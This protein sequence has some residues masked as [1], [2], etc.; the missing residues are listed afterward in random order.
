MASNTCR[1]RLF[2]PTANAPAGRAAQPLPAKLTGSKENRGRV[3]TN[4]APIFDFMRSKAH[5]LLDLCEAADG[6][7]QILL[8]MTGG[9]L[10][11]DAVAALRDD[12]IAEAD[13]IDALLEHPAREFLRRARIVE[14]DRNDRMLTGKQVEAMLFH[15]R[16]EIARVGMDAVAQLGGLLKQIDGAQRCCAD[17]GRQRI[18][19]EIGAGTLPQQIDDGL[20]SRSV[21]AGGAAHG[22]TEGAGDDVHPAHDA[23]VFRR[24]AAM[25]THE[26]DGVAVVHHRQRVEFIRKVAD[27]LQVGDIAVHGE[28][29]VGGDENFLAAGCAGRLELG[30]QIVHIVVLIAE[31]LRL[32][33]T[34]AVDDGGVVQLVGNDGV[35][36]AEQRLEQAAV[37][38]EAGGIEDGVVRTDEIGDPALQL[39]MNFLRAADE[40]DRRKAEAPAVI[41]FLRSFDQRG[42]GRKTEIIV[43]AEVY[44]ALFVTTGTARVWVTGVLNGLS[45]LIVLYLVRK[46]ENSAYKV[47]WIALIGLLPLL[48]GALYLAFG[49]KR[50][51]RRL[52]SKMQAVEQ[53]HRAD[54]AQQPGQTAG[55]YDENRGVSRYLTQYGCY[56]AWQ[57]TTARYFSC[58]EAMYPTLLADLEKAE[59]SIFLEFFIVSQGKMWQGV[60]DI[61]RRKAA[62]GVDV[63]LIYD[64]FGS[65]LGLPKD[66][67]V[68]MERA[69]IRCIPFNPV[70]PLLSLVMNH[71]DHRKIVV[72][73]GKVAYTGGINLADE[74]INAITRFGYWKDAG[75]RIEGAAVWNFTVM[76]LDFW[77]AFRPFEQDY[78]AFRPQLAV[79]PASDGVVQPYA[80]SPLDEE[81]VAETV[82]L[83]ILAQSQQYVYFYTPYLA[84]G[85]E[86]LDALRNA[87]KRGVDVRLVLPG[88][89]DKKLVFRLSR[90]Y[91]LP[92]LR[93][94]VRIYEYTPGFLHAKCCVSDDRAAVVGSINMDY[95]S[96]F[97][98]FECGVLLLQNSQV[99]ALRDDVRRT[100]PQCREVQ[101]ADCRT[102]LAGTVLDSVLRLLSPLM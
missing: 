39:L 31:A 46:D 85:E 80:D 35:L 75:L 51:S 99:L 1:W 45:L 34:H 12:R 76:F 86:M 20:T 43:G 59:K 83:D 50:P 74:Y 52:R 94:G 69:H 4:A 98:H 26:A 2:L 73:D 55:L 91:Y 7:I 100:L 96:M 5:F 60:E 95:R 49:N 90:S 41:A 36:R 71:R 23:A 65:L 37:G 10:R 11:A 14:H 15:L 40:A 16:A 81:P 18:G 28:H 24:A 68:R 92:L 84:I 38:V 63:R 88:I 30:A 56:P 87:A 97:L 54:R 57:N 47:G 44:D 72:I 93:A 53:A 9:D 79:L 78:S 3:L 89:P 66:F 61:L 70:V 21:A 32:A 101:C 48:G 102:G 82:Y 22:L 62:Q 25:L 8:R 67:V 42:M 33:E 64:D 58:G 6:K 19:E 17:G 29:A 27:G 13:D 77:N